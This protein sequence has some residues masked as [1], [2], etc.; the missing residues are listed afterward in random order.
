MRHLVFALLA[1]LSLAAVSLPGASTM[2][3]QQPR[4][5][6]DAFEEDFWNGVKDSGRASAIRDYLWLFPDGRFAEEAD[7][8]IERLRARPGEVLPRRGRRAEPDPARP[9]RRDTAATRPDVAEQPKPAA[10][11][12]ES[13]KP[14]SGT[15]QAAAAPRIAFPV[16]P[17]PEPRPTCAERFARL[18]SE[19]RQTLCV[20]FLSS[21][22]FMFARDCRP[23]SY[24]FAGVSVPSEVFFFTN[25]TLLLRDQ[26]GSSLQ[27]MA[28]RPNCFAINED[29]PEKLRRYQYLMLESGQTDASICD[30]RGRCF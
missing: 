13:V 21:G 15:D 27:T 1:S 16:P 29:K 28:G 3:Q 12:G 24:G 2:A 6:A 25:D 23:H 7:A 22:N 26:D 8:E 19:A 20:T 17:Q 11:A 10:N 4:Q 14:A 30:A 5:P 9:S 18:G